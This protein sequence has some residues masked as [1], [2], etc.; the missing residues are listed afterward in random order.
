MVKMMPT[1]TTTTMTTT[2]MMM[3]ERVYFGIAYGIIHMYKKQHVNRLVKMR[4][5]D[6][7]EAKA[8]TSSRIGR[9]TTLTMHQ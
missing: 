5:Q 9:L 7:N 1:A 4:L 2:L 8:V 3:I 6:D